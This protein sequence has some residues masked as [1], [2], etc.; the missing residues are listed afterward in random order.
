MTDCRTPGRPALKG[1]ALSARL[2]LHLRRRPPGEV[3]RLR[4]LVRGDLHRRRPGQPAGQVRRRRKQRGDLLPAR[5]R[6]IDRGAGRDRV[7]AERRNRARGDR[8]PARVRP[9]R[10]RPAHDRRRRRGDDQRALPGRRRRRRNRGRGRQ[11]RSRRPAATPQACRRAADADHAV[12]A[13]RR[14]RAVRRPD[15][16]ARRQGGDRH[17]LHQ[18]RT[19]RAN[20]SSTRS[21]T[22]A[23]RSPTPAAA[24]R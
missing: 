2:P 10:R 9:D 17:R 14:L 19:A 20:G 16:L 18:G 13:S 1:S 12:P 4:D 5:R 8:L 3:D 7:A 23:T 11:G 6:R 22:G 15:L 21:R 24:S